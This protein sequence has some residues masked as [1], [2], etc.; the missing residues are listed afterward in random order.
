MSIKGNLESFS[1]G[2]I[3]QSLSMNQHTGTLVVRDGESEKKIYF[4]RGEISL[5]ATGE[6]ET[7]KLGD[8]LIK[9]HFTTPENIQK[10]LKFQ[11]K[12]GK[13]LGEILLAAKIIT[14]EQLAAALRYKIEEE[15]YEL[16]LWEKA[17]FEFLSNYMSPDL[18]DPL[19]KVTKLSLNANSLIMESLRRIDEWQRIHKV[20]PDFHIVFTKKNQ[21]PNVIARADVPESHKKELALVDGLRSV[22]DILKVSRLNKFELCTLLYEFLRHG[23]VGRHKKEDYVRLAEKSLKHRPWKDARKFYLNALDM[24]P[25]DANLRLIFANLLKSKKEY[26]EAIDQFR[27][28]AAYY[29]NLG[30]HAKAVTHLKLTLELDNRNMEVLDDLLRALENMDNLAEARVVA[31]K[32]GRIAKQ[33]LDFHQAIE[34]YQKLITWE[35][36]NIE[37]YR[38]LA[39]CYRSLNQKEFAG[40]YYETIAEKLYARE[41]YEESAK[42]LKIVLSM[43]SSR[44]DLKARLAEAQRAQRR[45]DR[46]LLRRLVAAIIALAVL[47]ILFTAFDY[48]RSELSY[49][50]YADRKANLLAEHNYSELKY[51]LETARPWLPFLPLHRK[52]DDE[53]KDLAEKK[54]LYDQALEDLKKERDK[55]IAIGIGNAKNLLERGE[56]QSAYSNLYT[57]WEQ[58]PEQVENRSDVFF[59]MRLDS[60]PRGALAYLNGE[61]AGQTPCV[62]KYPPGRGNKVELKLDKFQT[63][64]VPVNFGEFQEEKVILV[65][66]PLWRVDLGQRLSSDPLLS[67]MGVFAPLEN[68][69]L[70]ALKTDTGEIMWMEKVT[71]QPAEKITAPTEAQNRYVFFGLG[72]GGCRSFRPPARPDEADFGGLGGAWA[73]PVELPGSSGTVFLAGDSKGAFIRVFDGSRKGSALSFEGVVKQRPA[74][75]STAVFFITDRD[76][77]HG[78]S[79]LDEEFIFRIDDDAT[80]NSPGAADESYFYVCT[81]DGNC[82]A[83]DV[84]LRGSSWAWVT[85]MKGKASTVPVVF[86]RR[87]Y[88]TDDTGGIYCFDRDTGGVLWAKKPGGE[89]ARGL[90]V[91]DEGLYAAGGEGLFVL[92]PGRG[93]VLWEFRA[94]ADDKFLPFAGTADGKILLATE[95]G[96]LILLWE[97]K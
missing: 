37:Y 3:F 12:T 43:D 97:K 81:A 26:D 21:H 83:V 69:S 28:L 74:A 40:R 63:A 4:A 2:E 13:K 38:E 56:L 70:V 80:F 89:F 35:P 49:R 16:F 24:D 79:L 17:D 23:V 77:L 68:G 19:S 30:Q 48:V 25:D 55:N 75:S 66:A 91:G 86:N 15:I 32:L 96:S 8:Y 64:R 7:T 51:A 5:L 33:E 1:L 20:I 85:P 44:K 42:M 6:R 62:I 61:P 57:L 46:I 72:S 95:K 60:D 45:K 71:R 22:D 87:V 65:R 47:F 41:E 34:Y 54:R 18:E 93:K 67:S 50:S 73:S 11:K 9:N 53:K 82:R 10:A 92:D 27:K 58:Y 31:D 52:I 84:T 88:A 36:E 76:V 94:H 59:P 29:T 90:A 14:K 39:E 78:Y